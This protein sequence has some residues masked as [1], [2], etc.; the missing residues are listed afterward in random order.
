MRL[1]IILFVF[2][3]TISFGQW[4]SFYPEKENVKSK[5][6]QNDKNEKKT[7]LYNNL[8]FNAIKQ[9]SLENFDHAIKLFEKCIEEKPE[10]FEAYYQLSLINKK[11]NRILEAKDQA[12]QAVSGQPKNIWY[13][14]NYADLLFLNQE[15]SES[16]KSYNKIIEIEPNNE[17]NYYKLADTYIYSEEYSKA[18]K[19]YDRLEQK[20]G[21][22]KMISM[23]KHKL[24]LQLRNFSKAT[25][26]L[27]NLSQK[28][29]DDIEVLQILAE[30]YILANK[31]AEAMKIYEKISEND[32]NNGQLNL[33]LAN[34]YRD[35]GDFNKSFSE[36]KKAFQSD[37]V[38]IETK[39]TILASYLSIINTNDTIKKQ[40]F[41][42]AKI[43]ESNYSQNA[44]VYAIYGDLFYSLNEKEES[45]KYYKKSLNIKQDIKAVWTQILFLDV[46]SA[47]YDS[48]ILYSEKA[49]LYYPSEPLYYYFFG[50]SNSYFK[51]YEEARV[52]LE[53]GI[54]YVFDNDALNTEFQISLADNYN[55]LELF[56]KSDS[57][58]KLILKN[59]PENIL[60]LNNYSYYL[61]LRKENLIEAK[62]MS[63]KC[64]DLEPN[65][66]TYQDTYAWVLYCLGE[67]EKAKLWLEKALKNGGESSAVI[68]EHYG[69]V[70]FKMGQKNEAVIQWKK[71]KSVGEGSKFLDKK[72]IN[73]ELYE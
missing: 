11:Y 10:F 30:A 51:N 36:L 62:E 24:Y 70:L 65:N 4:K 66:G 14:R 15:F 47:N 27:E 33:T 37:K 64:N 35:N 59:N 48:L 41:Q 53:T 1:F 61:S 19:V 55:S 28:F 25:K 57:L 43:L 52:A 29:P 20:K 21:V 31:Q 18:I 46:E 60:V 44:E 45:K 42:L 54:E 8:F 17:F 7:L 12:F 23:Q 72:I 9:K 34:F 32:P 13:L 73:E 6:F 22:D 2:S 50:V 16:A 39:L 40:A 69:D 56:S 63:K 68:I 58:Y 49:I 3:S 67:Y 26:T 5:Q 71:S 38:N